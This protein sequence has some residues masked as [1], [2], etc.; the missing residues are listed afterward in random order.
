MERKYYLENLVARSMTIG[1]EERKCTE[2]NVTKMWTILEE[3]LVN[4]LET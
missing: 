4:G 1:K 3:E 2:N